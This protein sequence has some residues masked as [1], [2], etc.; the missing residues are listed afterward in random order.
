VA[1]P[2]KLMRSYLKLGAA[3]EVKLCQS[4]HKQAR[5]LKQL[6]NCTF[7]MISGS[8][9]YRFQF[10]TSVSKLQPVVEFNNVYTV[11]VSRLDRQ[12]HTGAPCIRRPPSPSYADSVSNSYV[13]R[14]GIFLG[15]LV[16]AMRRSP[17]QPIVA[18]PQ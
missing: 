17:E 16:T 7:V 15:H 9:H 5:K 3:G 6:A 13:D 10:M 8:S 2:I 4:T 1:G 11:T 14:N 12:Y 18:L